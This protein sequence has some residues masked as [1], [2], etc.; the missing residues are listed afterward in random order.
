MSVVQQTL[1]VKAHPHK[2]KRKLLWQD[3]SLALNG[4]R[5]KPL[6]SGSV[7]VAH[8]KSMAQ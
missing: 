8:R 1:Q 3:Y 4:Y 6:S 2:D 7:K 5:W